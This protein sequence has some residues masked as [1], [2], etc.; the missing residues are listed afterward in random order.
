LNVQVNAAVAGLRAALDAYREQVVLG[1]AAPGFSAAL[2]RAG[3]VEGYTTPGELSLLYHLA[4]AA[5]GPGRIVEIG[6][7]LGRSTVVLATAVADTGREPVVAIDPHTA[8][9][10]IEGLPP[11]DTRA[12]FL[13][14][15]EQA[16]V[17]EHVELVHDYSVK[18][19]AGWDGA[20][21]RLHFVDGWHS[22][23]AVLEDVGAWAQWFTPDAVA[24]FDDYLTSD[25]VRQAVRE[26]QA[27][28]ILRRDGLVVGKMAAFGPPH[29]LARAPA[30]PG[31][32]ALMR[33]G[34]DRRERLIKLAE[35]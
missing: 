7:Y 31:G 4:V 1:N 26:L 9:L 27:D 24:V 2:Q 28:G 22:R 25:G 14:N 8:A 13:A 19:A 11:R 23:E 29:L 17:R 30:A 33:L 10:M 16:G 5:D 15:L 34:D 12:E 18:A 3:N 32:R 35:R 6:S 21:I 20:P